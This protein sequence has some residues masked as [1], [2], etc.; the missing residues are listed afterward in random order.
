MKPITYL[1]LPALLALLLAGAP[2]HGQVVR[3]RDLISHR[4]WT[5][6]EVDTFRQD[7]NRRGR[8]AGLEFKVVLG[9]TITR[10]DTI[11]HEYSLVGVPTEAALLARQQSLNVFVGQPLPAFA[12]P[13]M[14]GKLLDSKSLQGK[15]VVLNLWF[16]SCGPCIVEMPTLNR[17]QREKTQ[18]D[19]VFLAMTRDSQA[20]VQ[21][22]LR[23]QPFTYRQ[24]VGAKQYCNQFGMGYPVTFFV[25]RD[26]LIKRVL[27][28]I[29]VELDP[30]THQPAKA[31]DKDFYAALKQIE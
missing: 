30:A 19:I 11:I 4:L 21:A 28:S 15:P 8:P 1:P 9:K 18:T 14:Q 5:P 23:K 26:G 12:L 29:A 10:S 16:T 2:A 7:L 3:Y 27:G 31:D 24:L 22:F 17:I 25:G 6:T 13:D 20:Q